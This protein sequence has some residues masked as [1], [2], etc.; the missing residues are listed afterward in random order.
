MI[1]HDNRIIGKSLIITGLLFTVVFV[2][3]L[4]I[5]SNSVVRIRGDIFE[6][7]QQIS[8]NSSAY[9][10]G[11]L[12]AGLTAPLTA[13]LIVILALF[14]QTRKTTTILNILSVFFL[15][16]YTILESVA[17]LSQSTYFISALGTNMN[18][19]A[20]W[21]FGNFHSL[22]YFLQQ[23]GYLFFALSGI[24]LGYRY[25]L[26][27][28]VKRIFGIFIEVRCFITLIAFSGLVL[29]NKA[30]NNATL[31]SGSLTIFLGV[32]ALL[33]GRRLIK[34]ESTGQGI[35]GE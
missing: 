20:E 16:P 1:K 21:Y 17:Y 18:A 13:V 8:E 22:C 23:L 19:A 29:D 27:R 9:R 10:I 24:L 6:Q 3:G 30:L 26:D 25:C 12:F 33:I 7:L 15:L 5:M 14:V 35:A 2:L 11:F 4:M 28:G 34:I 31:I 32:F